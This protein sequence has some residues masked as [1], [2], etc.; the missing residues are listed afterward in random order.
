MDRSAPLAGRLRSGR[1]VMLSLAAVIAIG[2]CGSSAAGGTG[3]GGGG[4]SDTD[5]IIASSQFIFGT[6]MIGGEVQ[7]DTIVLTLRNGT[8][9]A[10]AG[11]FLCSKLTTVSAQN[12]P[13]GTFTLV[14]VDE[15]GQ[16]LSSSADCK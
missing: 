4:A 8:S 15:S 6:T 11:L 7:G 3:G 13:S 16:Q 9:K 14:A 2:A 1:L 12:D 10:M 5:T